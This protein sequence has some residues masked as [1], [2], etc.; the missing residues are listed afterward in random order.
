MW[1]ISLPFCVLY[2]G[3]SRP[4]GCKRLVRKHYGRKA[5]KSQPLIRVRHGRRTVN[6]GVPTHRV[7]PEPAAMVERYGALDERPRLARA[8]GLLRVRQP[9]GG[10]GRQRNRAPV[11][12]LNGRADARDRPEL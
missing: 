4:V 2:C 11:E 10:D 6:R 8:V 9:K 1:R 7:E 12:D 3:T 5:T